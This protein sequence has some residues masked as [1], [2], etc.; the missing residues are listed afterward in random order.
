MIKMENAATA[1]HTKYP[2]LKGISLSAMENMTKLSNIEKTA[3]KTQGIL[4]KDSDF[5]IP[6]KNKIN[7]DISTLFNRG[8]PLIKLERWGRPHFDTDVEIRS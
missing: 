3:K 7:Q 2:W 1:S 6:A 8:R 4:V 5:W